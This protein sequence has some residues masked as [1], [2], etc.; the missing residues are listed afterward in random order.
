MGRMIN[1]I[2]LKQLNRFLI[3]IWSKWWMKA[4]LIYQKVDSFHHQIIHSLISFI[5]LISIKFQN[6]DHMH[7]TVSLSI[8]WD[9]EGESEINQWQLSLHSSSEL[10]KNFVRKRKKFHNCIV[11]IIISDD[12]SRYE[13][14]EDE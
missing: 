1:E 2:Q 12:S 3:K 8:Y 5:S 11:V 10:F 4:N 13:I 7:H 9:R 6:L 14:R